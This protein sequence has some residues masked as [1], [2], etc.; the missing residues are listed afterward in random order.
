MRK[1]VYL[2]VCALWLLTCCQQASRK[3][4]APRDT[5][6]NKNNSYSG[7]FFDSATMEKFIAAEDLHD[8]LGSR[9]RNFYNARNYQYA[10]FL[11]SGVAE[12]VPTFLTLQNDYIGYSGDSTL[13]DPQLQKMIDSIR[14]PGFTF[15]PA[16]PMIAN[17]ELRLTEQFFRYARRAYQG[18]GQLAD[19]LDWFIP[20]KKID[21]ASILDSLIRNKGKSV[22]QYEPVN[23][24]YNLLKDYLLKYYQIQKQ[25]GWPT[26]NTDKK[27]FKEGDTGAAVFQ[28][29]RRLYLTADLP[30]NDTTPLFTPALTQAVKEF[31]RRFG[32]TQS[33][34]VGTQ[35][36]KIMNVPVNERIRQMLVNMERIRWVPAQPPADYVLI[37]I[38]EFRLHMYENNNYAWNMNI[39]AGSPAHST[40]I[41][42][43]DLKYVVFSPYWNVPNGILKKEVLPGIKRDKN[44]LA[45]HNM[46][47]NGKSVRQKPGPNNSL[48]LVKFLFPNSYDI[49]LHDTPSKSLFDKDS[50]AFSHGCIRLKE[51]RKLAQYLLRND[52][53]WDSVKIVKAMNAKKEQYVTLKQPLP[54]YIGYFTSWVDRNGKLNFRDDIYGHD[55]KMIDHMFAKK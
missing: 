35:L 47:W 51:P 17:T 14:E 10:W 16:D 4:V 26:I 21:A 48:G 31:Q 18:R 24:Q 43:G 29:K 44:Y 34:T 33:G 30:E 23:R 13:F 1:S 15:K 53:N 52:P 8:S 11:D 54:V 45:R 2:T 27:L 28:I 36:I 37:N 9:I 5:T 32:I 25:G 40:V 20:R 19:S 12:Y 55:K 7:L 3:P 41:F 22:T 42:S 49:Y 46:E 6:I 39:V 50:R 38:P